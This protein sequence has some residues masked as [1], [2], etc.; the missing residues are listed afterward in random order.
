MTPD[1]EV[2]LSELLGP[3]VLGT[4]PNLELNQEWL[5]YEMGCSDDPRSDLICTEKYVKAIIAYCNQSDFDLFVE[6]QHGWWLHNPEVREFFM[7]DAM[8]FRNIVPN[9]NLVRNIYA[10][11]GSEFLLEYQHV[12]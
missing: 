5:V 10:L 2:L 4:L 1:L 3:W 6:Q 7:M 9:V 12:I 11:D 8:Y